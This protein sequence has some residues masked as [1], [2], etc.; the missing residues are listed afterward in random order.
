[1]NKLVR[2]GFQTPISLIWKDNAPVGNSNSD[3]EK[4]VRTKRKMNK[5]NNSK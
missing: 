2:K 5:G 1:M 4:I 3:T